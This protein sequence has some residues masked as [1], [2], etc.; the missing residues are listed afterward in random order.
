MAGLDAPVAQATVLVDPVFAVVGPGA[1]G[2]GVVEVAVEVGERRGPRRGTGDREDRGEGDEHAEAATGGAGGIFATQGHLTRTSPEQTG[3]Q[4]RAAAVAA[5]R[6]RKCAEPRGST[7]PDAAWA[8]AYVHRMAHDLVDDEPPDIEALRRRLAAAAGPDARR[9]DLTALLDEIVDEA[10][11]DLARRP[12]EALVD[13][14]IDEAVGLG[15]IAPLMRD[16]AVTEIM[17][18]GPGAVY[19]ERAG[20]IESAPA[21]FEDDDHVRHVI[22]RIIAPLGRRLDEAN[23]MVDA[24]LPNGARVNAVI[25]PLSVDGPTLSVRIFPGEP[26][27]GEDL[28]AE[29]ALDAAV[30]RFL[31]AAVGERQ[32]ILVSG[33]TSSGKTTLLAALAAAVSDRERIITIEDSAELRIDAPHVV[34]LESRPAAV[35]G[36][37]PVTIRDLV[38]NA[39]RMRPDRIVVGEVRG[40]ECLDMVMAMTT[41]HDGSMSTLHASSPAEALDRL[42][43]LAMMGGGELPHAAVARQIDAAIDLIVHVERLPSGARRVGRIARVRP[44]S[45]GPRLVPIVRRS[46]GGDDAPFIWEEAP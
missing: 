46:G 35:E 38:R 9:E 14:V 11:P 30:L 28:V 37:P 10:H 39:L 25:P 1:G 34:R 36:R 23:P 5:R 44:G 40:P 45:D 26:L 20:R 32:N 6:P 29:G 7:A 33:G 41:G 17:V 19:A 2:F 4:H 21:R 3:A 15:P 8:P 43:L 31:R 13:A 27:S 42:E 16:P 12:R 18:N 24:R 22:D